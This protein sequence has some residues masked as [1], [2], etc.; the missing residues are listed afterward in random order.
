[1]AG[2][3]PSDDSANEVR[4]E[5]GSGSRPETR[6]RGVLWVDRIDGAR[7]VRLRYTT[8]TPRQTPDAATRQWA[9]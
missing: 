3:R 7:I 1:M 4:L 5:P 6:V 9:R 2:T 8:G